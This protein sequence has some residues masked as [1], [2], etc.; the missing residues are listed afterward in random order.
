MYE[1]PSRAIARLD[2]LPR[3]VRAALK[4][5][6]AFYAGLWALAATALPLSLAGQG[7]ILDLGALRAAI[8]HHFAWPVT[9][10]AISLF[11]LLLLDEKREDWPMSLASLGRAI[12]FAGFFAAI[13]V[14]AA[15]PCVIVAKI[16]LPRLGSLVLGVPTTSLDLEIVGTKYHS[17]PLGKGQCATRLFLA[18]PWS[19]GHLVTVCTDRM[20]DIA[21]ARPGDVLRLSGTA[22]PF[23]MNYSE[24][25]VIARP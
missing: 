10:L 5:L 6:W 25:S 9:I 18:D 14:V 16:A 12:V 21:K 2:R 11:A 15:V 7:S 13:W 4:S 19:A 3:P 8:D 23:G 22:S 24:I 1:F 20:P 17:G